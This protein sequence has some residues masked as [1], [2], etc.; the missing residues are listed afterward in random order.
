[1][2]FKAHVATYKLVCTQEIFYLSELLTMCTSNIHS[3]AFGWGHLLVLKTGF[4]YVGDWTHAHSVL[5][6]ATPPTA[7]NLPLGIQK[8]VQVFCVLLFLSQFCF[9]SPP[10]VS[11]AAVSWVRQWSRLILHCPLSYPVP[12]DLS[13]EWKRWVQD[14]IWL[15]RKG[16]HFCLR[17]VTLCFEVLQ[18]NTHREHCLGNE[19]LVYSDTRP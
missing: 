11:H 10:F 3:R 15:G 16:I 9:G 17:W 13:R 1:M 18:W 19:Y 7:K 6:F 5:S 2:T 14:G 12:Q 8:E 4:Q